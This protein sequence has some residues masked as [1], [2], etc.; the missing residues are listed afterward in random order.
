M[1]PQEK[2]FHCLNSQFFTKENDANTDDLAKIQF[3]EQ[4]WTKLNNF[5]ANFE[6]WRHG[7]HARNALL[8]L[9]QSNKQTILH[10]KLLF[11]FIHFSFLH[12]FESSPF[13]F[14]WMQFVGCL[15]INH[16]RERSVS[17]PDRAS[18]PL[19][20]KKYLSTLHKITPHIKSGFIT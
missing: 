2:V 8:P 18:P 1:K 3:I 16:I 19:P 4:N 9:T 5:E 20:K 7:S 11:F 10:S 15:P 17:F 6:S 14:P 13:S 12:S